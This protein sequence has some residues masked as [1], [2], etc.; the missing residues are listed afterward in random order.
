MERPGFLLRIAFAGAMIFFISAFFAFQELRYA[1]WG[2]VTSA[3]VSEAKLVEHDGAQ[4]LIVKYSFQ[5][6]GGTR[7]TEKDEVG[8][9]WEP[10]AGD[11]LQVDYLPGVKDRSRIAGNRN[12]LMLYIFLGSLLF[13]LITIAVLWYQSYR[14]GDPWK[15]IHGS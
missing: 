10:P 1:I 14:E 11:K 12:T 7:R 9:D 13:C 8:L 2:K 4:K 15:G 6:E 3:D 5:E